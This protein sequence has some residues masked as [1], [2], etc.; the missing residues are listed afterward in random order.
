MIGS[1]N[2]L[3]RAAAGV[4]VP[5]PTFVEDYFSIDAYAGNGGSQ[6]LATSVDLSGG[7]MVWTK[8][9]NSSSF[10]HSVTD[11]NSNYYNLDNQNIGGSNSYTTFTSS[12]YTMNNSF[13]NWNASSND[14]IS[15]TFSKQEKFFDMVDYTG[16]GS[17]IRDISHSLG[18]KPAIV[19]LKRKTEPNGPFTVKALGTETGNYSPNSYYQSIL[20]STSP[21]WSNAGFRQVPMNDSYVR[22]DHRPQYGIVSN[23]SGEE[24]T[25]YF[26]A[27]DSSD[28]GLSVGGS[29]IGNGSTIAGPQIDLGWEPQFVFVKSAGYPAESW[30]VFDNH[31]GISRQ[32]ANDLVINGKPAEA[33]STFIELLS[34]GF[35][36]TSNSDQV[37]KNTQTYVYWA[38][39]RG[40]MREP[41]SGSQVVESVLRS[42]TGADATRTA[43][44]FADV[45]MTANLPGTSASGTRWFDRLRGNYISINSFTSNAETD[46]SSTPLDAALIGRPNSKD[47]LLKSNGNVNASG[48]NNYV[49]W[50]W[51]R[52]KKVFDVVHYRGNNA[53]RTIPHSLG[54]VPQFIITKAQNNTNGNAYGM[55]IEYVGPLAP[56]AT[57][58]GYGR[59]DT[60]DSLQGWQSY[61]MFG[62]KPTATEFS[63]SSYV[64]L[65]NAGGYYSAFLWSNLAGVCDIGTYTGVGAGVGSQYIDC[66]FS[67]GV[68]WLFITGKTST[69]NRSWVFDTTR[70]IT[71]AVS[72]AWA[73]GDNIAEHTTDDAVDPSNAG[74][75]VISKSTV[76]VN[77][78]NETYYYVAIA[79]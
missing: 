67:S 46:L 16:N 38:I 18:C 32:N 29:Y 6:S 21:F 1:N 17:E 28:T 3:L 47:Y 48:T 55:F 20:N 5:D 27:H 9:R 4:G 61:D 64:G 37:N 39:R 72:P 77:E 14:Y 58:T 51:T 42:G 12:G 24:Y 53:N 25:L 40:P 71:T 7:G 50:I 19:F 79:A 78:L 74:F 70:G 30:H 62:D 44:N 45:I 54:A 65:N 33:D 31:R 26:F 43:T 41:T 10:N 15:Y 60:S 76:N 13:G 56:S 52:R 34:T 59:L 75:R 36:T 22:L 63:L 23:T 49:D 11:S 57:S 35:K 8:A 66:G 69:Y 73:W 68:R 2:K